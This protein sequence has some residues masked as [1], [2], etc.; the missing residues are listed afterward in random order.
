MK[1]HV[2]S[3][4]LSTWYFPHRVL[5]WI[6]RYQDNHLLVRQPNRENSVEILTRMSTGGWRAEDLNRMLDMLA[7]AWIGASLLSVLP[8]ALLMGIGGALHADIPLWTLALALSLMPGMFSFGIVVWLH[9]RSVDQQRLVER[10]KRDSLDRAASAFRLPVR[11]NL[12]IIPLFML[13][14]FVLISFG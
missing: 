6:A 13:I 2:D 5:W 3:A 10:H 11:R 7:S 12:L 9:N 8:G 4:P 1:Y 14:A